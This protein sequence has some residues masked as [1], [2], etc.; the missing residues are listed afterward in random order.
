MKTGK[1]PTQRIKYLHRDQIEDMGKAAKERSVR[2]Y[3]L[4]AF[5]YRFGMRASEACGLLTTDVDAKRGEV[6]IEGLKNGLERVYS[7]P[8]DLVRLL[9]RYTPGETYFFESRQGTGKLARTRLWAIVK[10]IMVAAGIPK[11]FTV[12]SI[13]HS[14]AVHCLDAGGGLE[15]VR[16][17]L[18]HRRIDSTDIY[19]AI[20]PKRRGDYFGKMQRSD[21]V[22]KF[23]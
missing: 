9:K 1:R 21:S 4:L 12:H 14:A 22:V 23:R 3:L 16:D 15:D 8:R 13:R 20:S 10:E 7:L 11:G 19:G 2:D 5:L 17:L 6:R 18:R